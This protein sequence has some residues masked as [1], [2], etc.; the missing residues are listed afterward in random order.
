MGWQCFGYLSLLLTDMLHF[1]QKLPSQH[2][3]Q[4]PTRSGF[5][6]S[7]T[8][9]SGLLSP[10]ISYAVLT[11]GLCTFCSLCLR[12]SFPRYLYGFL[13]RFLPISTQRPQ[14]PY[15]PNKVPDTLHPSPS[16]SFIFAFSPYYHLTYTFNTYF[17]SLTPPHIYI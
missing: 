6:Q 2:S 16:P 13:P 9:N 10:H 4:G 12:C 14:C 1:T 17:L 11:Q 5:P 3:L 8:H 7:M 15:L